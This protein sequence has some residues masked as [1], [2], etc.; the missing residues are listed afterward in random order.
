MPYAINHRQRWWNEWHVK[1]I[2]TRNQQVCHA[3]SKLKLAPNYFILLLLICTLSPCNL[4]TENVIFNILH[5]MLILCK[6]LMQIISGW[7]LD[8]EN[9]FYYQ[10]IFNITHN[11]IY[12]A[13]V[14]SIPEQL[15]EGENIAASN[16]LDLNYRLILIY[17]FL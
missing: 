12:Q 4:H 14:T 10:L 8:T 2:I 15:E 17:F 13:T 3:I 7:N 5:I 1:D 9:F 6:I 11:Q 16:S